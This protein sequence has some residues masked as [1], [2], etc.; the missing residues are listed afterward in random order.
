MIVSHL[1]IRLTNCL[2]RTENVC[3]KPEPATLAAL[4]A[5]GE[6]AS[7]GLMALALND[8]AVACLRECLTKYWPGLRTVGAKLDADLVSVD[9][10]RLRPEL[11]RAIVVVPGFVGRGE[12]GDITLL[13]RGG[14]DFSALPSASSQSFAHSADDQTFARE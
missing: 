13:G 10:G 6:T 4:L 14:S 5:T 1:E 11:G 2:R 9:F 3:A 8:V 12:H 7:S